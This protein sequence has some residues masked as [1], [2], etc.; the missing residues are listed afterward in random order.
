MMAFQAEEYD[1]AIKIFSNLDNTSFAAAAKKKIKKAAQLAGQILRKKAAKLFQRAGN[2]TDLKAKKK[3]LLSSKVLLEK[4]LQKY[5]QA[6]L[7]AK[8]KRNLSRVDQD[9]ASLG[10]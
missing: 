5:P 7:E 10:I 2:A 1:Q 3:L 8:V 9:L 6:G 4:I